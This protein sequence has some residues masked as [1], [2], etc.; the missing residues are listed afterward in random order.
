MIDTR[1]M[2][3][4]VQKFQRRFPFT[5]LISDV[6]RR[7]V[8]STDS[9]RTGDMNLLAIES[10][11]INSMATAAPDGY[12]RNAGAAVPLHFQNS[13]IGAIVAEREGDGSGSPDQ[14]IEI[15]GNAVE[16]LY[17]ELLRSKSLQNQTQERD[18]FLYEWLHLQAEHTEAFKKRGEQ[19]GI[20]ITSCH[21]VF[22]M[23]R[24][25]QNFCFV[26]PMI[27]KLLSD[28]DIMISLSQDQDIL[29]LKEDAF[30]AKKYRRITA[31]A[32]GCHMGICS[33]LPHLHSA[34]QAAKDSL[35]LGKLL[36]PD[37][38]LHTYERMKLAITLSQIQVPGLEEAFASLVSRGKNAQLAE[39]AIAYIRLGGDVQKLCKN[40][41]IHRNSISY[42]LRRI[43]E[44]C[45]R[46]LTDPYD[47]L[48]L[49]AS[50][51]HYVGS[52]PDDF[53][54]SGL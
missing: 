22:L 39:T 18:Q 3:E 8:V 50:F 46:K 16:L 14:S 5:I 10:L 13:R 31:A 25:S 52:H 43:E 32:S 35:N 24:N 45:G 53:T 40:L 7:I 17:D 12:L 6:S 2:H 29:L 27:K 9:S 48:F 41:H 54:A 49:Y 33:G 4:I 15:L 23:D 21:T 34:Y 26:A 30:F 47:L 36:F 44:I 37:Q 42:R 11:N 28:T 19:L 20:D 38:H 51:I 1:L